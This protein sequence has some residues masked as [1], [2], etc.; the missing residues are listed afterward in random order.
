M[1]QLLIFLILS[2]VSFTSSAEVFKCKSPEGR[3]VYSE[4]P[5][6]PDAQSVNHLAKAPSEENVRAA[7]ARLDSNVRQ[8]DVMERQERLDRDRRDR[9]ARDAQQ[10]SRVVTVYVPQRTTTTTVV[11]YG[12]APYQRS[13][14]SSQSHSGK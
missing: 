3:I 1:N 7:Q 14:T 4:L 5:C 8:A 9:E 11:T 12:Q 2:M 6:A 13:T 10:T